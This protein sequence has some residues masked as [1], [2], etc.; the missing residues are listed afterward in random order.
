MS[1]VIASFTRHVSPYMTLSSI[2]S[3]FLCADDSSY[4]VCTYHHLASPVYPRVSSE[5]D[6]TR[7]VTICRYVMT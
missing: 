3:G 2:D 6:E 4:L 5:D 7:A 1:F